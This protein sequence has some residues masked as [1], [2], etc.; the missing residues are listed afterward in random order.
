MAAML[1]RA[2]SLPPTGSDHFDDDNGSTFENA[3]NKVA[4]AGI[5]VG[6]NPPANNNYCP[7]SVVNRGQMSAFIKRSVD[8]NG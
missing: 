2:L 4:D 1:A 7:T 3:I 8:L 6:C 5:T